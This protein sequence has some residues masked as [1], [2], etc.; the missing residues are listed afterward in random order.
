MPL[1]AYTVTATLPDDPTA[2]EYADWLHEHVAKVV[3]A[4]AQDGAIVR[5]QEPPTPIRVE[6]RYTFA[7]RQALDRYLHL[8]APGLRAEGLQRFGPDRGVTFD[9]KVGI[10]L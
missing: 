8:H 3:A 7:D 9:R 5:I 1:V 2:R 10:F 6:T 4:G